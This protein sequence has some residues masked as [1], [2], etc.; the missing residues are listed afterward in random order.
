MVFNHQQ[1]DQSVALRESLAPVGEGQ[2]VQLSM[3]VIRSE[4][5]AEVFANICQFSTYDSLAFGSFFSVL[6]NV[7]L[8]L[9]DQ[10]VTAYLSNITNG[11]L[12]IQQGDLV[13]SVRSNC[14]LQDLA[15][16]DNAAAPG[17]VDLS[18]VYFAVFCIFHRTH[19]EF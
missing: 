17:R 9:P 19:G 15:P 4:V 5:L 13:T 7:M 11:L 10:F 2:L 3:S 8:G 18:Q 14:V 6:G 1:V 16:G 12:P